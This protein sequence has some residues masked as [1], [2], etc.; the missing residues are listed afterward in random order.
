MQQDLV[1]PRRDRQTGGELAMASASVAA[2]PGI[3]DGEARTPRYAAA[4]TRPA[5]VFVALSVLFGVMI[6]FATPPLRGPDEAAHFLRAYGVA[7]GDIVPSQQDAQGRKGIFLPFDLYHG[8]TA[9]ETAYATE[10]RAHWSTWALPE[11]ERKAGSPVTRQDAV[12]VAYEGSEGYT[13]IP[14]L[15]YVPAAALARAMG[16]DFPSTLYLMRVSALIVTTVIIAY[17]IAIVPHFAWAFLCIGLLPA[18]LY[19]RAVIS[20]DGV[21]LAC[22]M[23]ATAIALR[24]ASGA[25][26]QQ[27]I[28]QSFWMTLA[29][30]SKPPT[31]VVLLLVLMRGS[32]KE[33]LSR[34][35]T[36]SLIVLPGLLA[37]AVWTIMTSG[38][39][40]TWRQVELTGRE[41][42]EF[43]AA[44]K[45]TFLLQRPMHFPLAVAATFEDSYWLWV[46][47]IGVMGLFD[48]LLQ[49]WVYPTLSLLLFAACLTPVDAHFAWRAR[50]A[51]VAALAAAAYALAV[52]LIFFLIWTPID[53]PAVRGVQ[54]RYF[55]PCLPLLAVSYALFGRGLDERLRAGTAVA[56]AALS[57]LMTVEAIL[58]VDWRIWDAAAAP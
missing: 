4:L 48:T 5:A 45:L 13:P 17:A 12:F 49:N 47:L 53:A 39:A 43:K 25:R 32:M 21:T 35:R 26:P 22:A 40:G 1:V 56:A 30:L 37:M 46:S 57:G 28:E 50:V 7:N 8:F 29:A 41:A 31:F 34:W 52:F 16:L 38:D 9:H 58:R 18:A 44:W 3:A 2:S 36:A 42:E 20:A 11:A 54:G 10:R 6:A 24:A 27:W 55:L 51:A 33:L 14:Y 19:G 23:A 15:P